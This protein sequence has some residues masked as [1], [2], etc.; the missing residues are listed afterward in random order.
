MKFR[1]SFHPYAITT[2]VFWSL[3]YVLTRLV[4]RHFSALSVGFLRYFAASL[5][6]L[7]V[8]VI[9]GIKPPA[10]RDA[11]WFLLAGALGFAFY[12]TAF[13][14][15]CETVTAATG[16]T[17]LAT[18]P[19]LTA[20]L[21]R[22]IYR[23][24]MRA[25]QWI[26]T[27][28]EFAGVIILTLMNG[29]F[30]FNPGLLWLFAAAVSLSLYNLLQRKLTRTYSGL[31]TSA[32]GIFAGTAMLSVFAPG[33]VREAVSA[34]PTPLLLLAVLGVF[35]SALGYGMWSQ[36]FKKAKLSSSV[37]NYMFVT[38]LLSSIF[39]FA[40]AGETPD[41]PTI[42]GGSVI[43]LGVLTFNFGGTLHPKT[44]AEGLA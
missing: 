43:L 5:A 31:Q 27:A 40:F 15:G 39:A 8:A 9:A 42:V 30:S 23:E 33:A 20:L 25:F 36:A 29:V 24:R 11:K 17:I 41:L 44:K 34:P 38:P 3:A 19:V 22:V 21:A 26:A 32:Y 18:V 6:L 10:R 16:S 37:S 2:I 7:I 14:K 4:M 12:V 28:V 35:S 13:N 1:D